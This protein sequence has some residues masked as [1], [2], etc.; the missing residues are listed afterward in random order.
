MW[1]LVSVIAGRYALPH[2]LCP[3]P[4]LHFLKVFQYC[5]CLL[6][7][8]VIIA[9][10]TATP[11]FDNEML[12]HLLSLSLVT[13][14]G[15]CLLASLLHYPARISTTFLSRHS[16]SSSCFPTFSIISSHL[17]NQTKTSRVRFSAVILFLRASI[18]HLADYIRS[19]PYQLLR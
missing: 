12:Q 6:L 2:P 8:V 18:W 17:S 5:L 3:L 13:S 4:M 19:F 9:V 14:S 1:K 15:N 7:V 11:P 10:A 16:L